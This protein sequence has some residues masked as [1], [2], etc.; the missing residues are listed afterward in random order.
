MKLVTTLLLF[1]LFFGWNAH[2][3]DLSDG[4]RFYA[5]CN[6]PVRA[7]EA[8]SSSPMPSDQVRAFFMCVSYVRGS[9]DILAALGIIDEATTTNGQMIDVVLK[10]L[11]NY[12]EKRSQAT[13]VLVTQALKAAFPPKGT[14]P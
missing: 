13:A 6:A 10:Y 2:A 5:F 12:P 4:N 7:F 3:Q 9:A 11:E 8:G 14:K 1:S